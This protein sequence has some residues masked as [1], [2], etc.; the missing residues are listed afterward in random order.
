MSQQKEQIQDRLLALLVPLTGLS[1]SE[2]AGHESLQGLGLES[3]DYIEIAHEISAAFGIQFGP[4]TL[5]AQTSLDDL[6]DQVVSRVLG[7][8]ASEETP[9]AEAPALSAASPAE[10]IAIIG[11]ALDVPGAADLDSLWRVMSGGVDCI[12]DIDAARPSILA[13]HLRDHDDLS[14]FPS[15]AGLVDGIENFDAAFF[16]ISPLEARSMD[17]QQRKLM[18]SCWRVIEDAGYRPSALSGRR[19]GVHCAINATDYADLL[20]RSP[21]DL[22]TCG[23]FADTG[24]HPCMVSNRISRWFGFQGP[25]ETLNTAC[26]GSLF[27]VHHAVR[28]LRDGTCEMAVAAAG[29]ALVSARTFDLMTRA[30]MLSPRGR[31]ATFDHQ[32]D[33]YVRSEGFVSVLLRPLS[34]AVATGDRVLGVIRGTAIGHDGRTDSLRAPSPRAQRDVIL[35]ALVDG[36]IPV[37]SISYVEA[38]GTGTELGDPI[39]VEGLNQAFS[40]A[41]SGH[42]PGSCGIGSVKTNVGHLESAAGLTGLVKVLSCLRHR[43]LPGLV[44]FGRVNPHLLLQGS[45]FRLVTEEEP[46]TPARDADGRD[47]PRRAGLSSFGYGGAIAHLV[48]EEAP[49]FAPRDESQETGATCLLLSARTESALRTTAARTAEH[50]RRHPGS[51]ARVSRGLLAREPMS[52]RLALVV[53]DTETAIR[54]LSDFAEQVA[55]A[56]SGV[57]V[58]RRQ[59]SAAG[60]GPASAAATS[61]PGAV[62]AGRD[63]GDLAQRWMTGAPG[64]WD[65]VDHSSDAAGL[66]AYPFD[67]T[68]HWI[69]GAKD[70]AVGSAT[71]RLHPLVSANVSDFHEQRF[72]SAFSGREALLRDHLVDGEPALPDA[73]WLEAALFCLGQSSGSDDEGP[74][75]MTDLL[76]GARHRPSTGEVG[77]VLMPTDDDAVDFDCLTGVG[78]DVLCQGNIRREKS[79]STPSLP[80]PAAEIVPVVSLEQALAAAGVRHGRSF[81]VVRALKVG[82]RSAWADV[83]AFQR[84]VSGPR[85]LLPPVPTT[86]A[87]EIAWFAATGGRPEIAMP[88]PQSIARVTVL[89]PVPASFEMHVSVEAPDSVDMTLVSA[90]RPV[91][92]FEGVRFMPGE[93]V[94]DGR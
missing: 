14:R 76:W 22:D 47:L 61:S 63:P 26:S 57:L 13:D 67:P 72:V 89:T 42:P 82:E 50:L 1:R 21:E 81:D 8:G 54:E 19:I 68:P 29:N 20:L 91:A 69:G 70:T 48:V 65:D 94:N 25:S 7:D 10:P 85:Y 32:A 84:G 55:G 92:T 60:D 51:L 17:P 33:G 75:V 6:L 49:P 41:G 16:G 35:A 45:P 31:C 28:A 46:W 88:R 36:D 83:R 15:R 80:E 56:G 43:R 18:E 3:V 44:H 78:Q 86:R 34:A 23:A 37:D 58:E 12:R 2:L 62:G 59:A 5:F 30:G 27:A 90:G 77:I 4:A 39:E 73:A 40:A 38:H 52:R 24:L 64:P 9:A 11:V 74:L 87:L 53:D 71:T 79:L 93:A 66:P